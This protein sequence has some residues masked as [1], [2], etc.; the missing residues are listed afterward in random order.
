MRK[1]LFIKGFDRGDGGFSVSLPGEVFDSAP[2]IRVEQRA[3]LQV[4]AGELR[5]HVRIACDLGH[6]LL[7]IRIRAELPRAGA[8]RPPNTVEQRAIGRLRSGFYTQG[9]ADHSNGL[10]GGA[11]DDA[12]AT[13]PL[14]ERGAGKHLNDWFHA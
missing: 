9:A 10:P 12:R 5:G 14:P 1:G 11:D 6:D 8:A 13:S 7:V 2:A 3:D 4:E